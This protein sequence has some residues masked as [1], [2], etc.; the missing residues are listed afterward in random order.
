[1]PL[2]RAIAKVSNML[3]TP[4]GELQHDTTGH[5]ALNNF[6]DQYNSTVFMP[7]R[8]GPDN[9][10]PPEG[11]LQQDTTWTCGAEQLY[12]LVRLNCVYTDAARTRQHLDMRR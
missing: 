4:E 7:M 12:R 11:E 1:M 3:P 5:A 6:T 10:Y 2:S 8:H 9:T